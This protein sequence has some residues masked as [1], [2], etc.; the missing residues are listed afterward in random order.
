M[1]K[2][3]LVFSLYVA[4]EKKEKVRSIQIYPYNVIQALLSI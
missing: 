4:L 3:K 1:T 2:A